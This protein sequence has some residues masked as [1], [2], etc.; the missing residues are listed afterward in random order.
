MKPIVKSLA[1]GAIGVIGASAADAYVVK[2]PPDPN[3]YYGA[4]AIAAIGAYVMRKKPVVVGALGGL[5]L[6][7]A[8]RGYVRGAEKAAVPPPPPRAPLPAPAYGPPPS[9]PYAYQPSSYPQAPAYQPA[10]PGSSISYADVQKYAQQGADIGKQLAETF[11]GSTPQSVPY[12]AP[13]MSDTEYYG[14][15]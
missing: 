2:T 12:E 5:A 10:A 11:G 9:Y 1:A 3:V 4:A 6:G 13:E 8:Y 7:A 14:S 15:Y